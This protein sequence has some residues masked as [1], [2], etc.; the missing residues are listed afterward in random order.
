MVVVTATANAAS[1]RPMVGSRI[2]IWC[3]MKPTC[4]NNASANGAEIVQNPKLRKSRHRDRTAGIALSC[5]VDGFRAWV[6]D[7]AFAGA[8]TWTRQMTVGSRQA[9]MAAVAVNIARVNPIVPTRRT[10]TGAIT[11]PPNVAP[12]NA[13]L[14]ASPR[15]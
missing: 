13:K 12:L 6:L 1:E 10:R 8:G 7:H 11:M 14:M 2:A 15:R 9:T 3:T 4:A 5:E